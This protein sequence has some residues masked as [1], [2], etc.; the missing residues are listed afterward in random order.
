VDKVFAAAGQFL[1]GSDFLKKLNPAAVPGLRYTTVMTKYDEAVVPYTSGFLNAPNATDVVLQD[2][3]PQDH[4]GHG[5]VGFDPNA[6]QVVLNA[7]DPAHAQP[8]H[9]S[10]VAPSP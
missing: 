4:A 3:C 2:I 1:T 6:T 5:M 9:C 8:I 7:L 10:Y